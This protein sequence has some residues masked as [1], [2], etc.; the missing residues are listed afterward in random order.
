MSIVAVPLLLLDVLYVEEIFQLGISV[1]VAPLTMTFL[2]LFYTD[3]KVAAGTSVFVPKERVKTVLIVIGVIGA[4]LIPLALLSTLAVVALGSAREKARD[5]R[6]VSDIRQ[7]QVGLE[8]YNADKGSYPSSLSE[9][10]PMFLSVIPVDPKS[11]EAY[12]YQLQD[13]AEYRLCAS[14][15]SKGSTCVSFED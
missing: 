4:M 14:F 13:G 1:L 7:I 2:F 11:K 3:L 9:V 5:A 10:S 8:L 6:R 15:E 12:T